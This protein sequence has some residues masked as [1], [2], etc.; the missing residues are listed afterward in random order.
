MPAR[1]ETRLNALPPHRFGA[2]GPS[3]RPRQRVRPTAC[4]G[5]PPWALATTGSDSSDRARFRL[6]VGLRSVPSR[7]VWASKRDAVADRRFAVPRF[8]KL[9]TKIH[10]DR[11][12]D[13]DRRAGRGERHRQERQATMPR[14]RRAVDPSPGTSVPDLTATHFQALLHLGGRAVS[15]PV[16]H[17]LPPWGCLVPH[18]PVEGPDPT[19]PERRGS[20]T[21][22]CGAFRTLGS[23]SRP[24]GGAR[25]NRSRTIA[26]GAYSLS[27]QGR[28]NLGSVPYQVPFSNIFSATRRILVIQC[29]LFVSWSFPMIGQIGS[30]SKLCPSHYPSS[31]FSL[32]IR[33]ESLTK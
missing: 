10:D 23:T 1:R 25:S 11:G 9:P 2:R 32:S 7:Q 29:H 13:G 14:L 3:R 31:N 5:P 6:L 8:P 15:A 20:R 22:S 27:R 12:D 18:R 4:D 30:V 17:V 33:S 24:G 16:R 26:V 28:L 19:P 21:S